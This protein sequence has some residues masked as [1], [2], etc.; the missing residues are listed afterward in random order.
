MLL[1]LFGVAVAVV[2]LPREELRVLVD[3]PGAREIP[4]CQKRYLF[5][6]TT[7]FSILN[8]LIDRDACGEK[9][10]G[11]ISWHSLLRLLLLLLLQ[12]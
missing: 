1:L 5:S 10:T 2:L 11:E 7:K 4:L 8:K 6:T 9:L 12:E 3:E